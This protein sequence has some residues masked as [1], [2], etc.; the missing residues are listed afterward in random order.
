M[1]TKKN[2]EITEKPKRKK[3]TLEQKID[4]IVLLRENNYN[5]KKTALETGASQECLRQWKGRYGDMTTEAGRVTAVQE[6]TEEQ[7]L[8]HKMDYITKH[9]A[10]LD[11]L[12]T[13]T[14]E[15][16]K[17][18]I[19][20]A[21]INEATNVLRAISD[22]YKMVG[23]GNK[24]QQQGRPPVDSISIIQQVIDKQMNINS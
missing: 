13:D 24:D 9:F 21:S 7:L 10:D 5:Y 8:Y 6:R 17:V 11:Q 18:L 2:K 14:I 19:P 16:I 23:M 1:R 4:A 22:I 3:F 20:K 12:T 15:R